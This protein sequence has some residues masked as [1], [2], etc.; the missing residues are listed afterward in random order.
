MITDFGGQL[1]L[2]IGG[3]VIV[4]FEYMTFLVLVVLFLVS[5]C[6]R[7]YHKN[8]KNKTDPI[9]VREWPSK[10]FAFKILMLLPGTE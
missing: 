1:G 9:E 2:W 7:C 8:K 3:S 6:I 10:Y 4:V 5:K